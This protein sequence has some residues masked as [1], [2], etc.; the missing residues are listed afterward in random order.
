MALPPPTTSGCIWIT[1]AS[2]GIGAAVALE[3]SRRG[4]R[5]AA[6]ARG[7]EGL[8]DL[9]SRAGPGPVSCF[10]LDVTDHDAVLATAR[11]IEQADG[12]ILGALLC[13]GTY[14][15]IAAQGFDA[16]EAEKQIAVNFAGVV[17]ALEPLLETMLERGQGHIAIVASLTSRFGLPRAGVYGATKAA[18][19][20]LAQALRAECRGQG[21]TVQVINPGFV[22]TP[23][24]DKNDFPM[25][26]LVPAERAAR[27]VADGM[28][29]NSFEI[30]FPWQISWATALLARL[31][32]RLA[33]AL[34]SRMVD[35]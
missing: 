22:K 29:G 25:P 15:P 33:F 34:T 4:Y 7:E 19:V 5:I 9:A 35:R 1:G 20:N 14:K 11:A 32:R 23:L 21:V 18:L 10:P 16:R 8:R 2:S 3:L 28:A 13:A 27:I 24:T 26:F 6:S 12:P 31:P 30:A 17:H